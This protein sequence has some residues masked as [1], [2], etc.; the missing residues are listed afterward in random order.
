MKIHAASFTEGVR[1]VQHD[2]NVVSILLNLR[3]RSSPQE[4]DA[5]LNF[6]LH[7]HDASRPR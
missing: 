4:A 5:A 7:Q 2:D 3:G 1:A 6:D